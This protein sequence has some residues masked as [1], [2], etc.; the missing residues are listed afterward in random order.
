MCV[1][2]VADVDL[3]THL[4]M[5]PQMHRAR[6]M[7]SLCQLATRPHW[8]WQPNQCQVNAILVPALHHARGCLSHPCIRTAASLTLPVS[9][10][11][12]AAYAYEGVKEAAYA[13]TASQL[14]F[15]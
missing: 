9:C 1:H 13:Y 2:T 8:D 3:R 5:E 6:V 14:R 12:E 11:R 15:A 10:V 7:A 4:A